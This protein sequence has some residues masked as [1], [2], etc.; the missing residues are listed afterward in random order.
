[1][2]AWMDGADAAASL[3]M[4]DDDEG[5]EGENGSSAQKRKRS[6]SIDSANTAGS[7]YGIPR[8]AGS[9]SR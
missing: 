9:H 3:L 6:G 2:S 1:M 4:D 7:F 5:G 8:K